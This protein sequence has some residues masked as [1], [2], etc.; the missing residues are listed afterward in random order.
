MG[1]HPNYPGLSVHVLGM[2]GYFNRSFGKQHIYIAV[3]PQISSE[4]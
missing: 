1:Q 4:K 3:M 2:L